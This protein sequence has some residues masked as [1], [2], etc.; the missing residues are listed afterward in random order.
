MSRVLKHL[1]K[2]D[3]PE[4]DQAEFERVELELIQGGKLQ[5]SGTIKS[6]KQIPIQIS[7]P[8]Q[9]SDH[10]D[11][12]SA[13]ASTVVKAQLTG[14]HATDSIIEL[15]N[16]ARLERVDLRVGPIIGIERDEAKKEK[17]A[18]S[19]PPFTHHRKNNVAR[20][21]IAFLL[22]MIAGL[23]FVR[24]NRKPQTVQ[25]APELPVLPVKNDQ[26]F[27]MAQEVNREAIALFH[28]GKYQE[29]LDQFLEISSKYPDSA[30]THTNLG[31]TYF[32]LGDRANA[33]SHLLTAV[34][35]NPKDVIAFNNL[36]I[37]SLSEGDDLTAVS[38]FK[39]AIQV[40]PSFPD[41]HLNLGK[42]LEQMGK[43]EKAVNEYRAYL[44]LPTADP[45]VKRVVSKRITK[46]TSISRYFNEDAKGGED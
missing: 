7:G 22:V 2:E 42:T 35:L 44:D 5:E 33:R 43:P 32:K 37:V 13:T 4:I 23:Y 11:V 24:I 40:S 26:S 30:S 20:M 6:E 25:V 46:L 19:P 45:V 9:S 41:S 31:M 39:K 36:G 1:L 27:L 8:V 18:L 28:A 21:V 16:S 17:A 34:T 15:K 38:Y 10:A 14:N 29:A 3:H 12:L